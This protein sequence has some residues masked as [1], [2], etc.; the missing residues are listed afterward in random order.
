MGDDTEA[1]NNESSDQPKEV[2]ENKENQDKESLSSA[3]EVTGLTDAD[4]DEDLSEDRRKS[5]SNETSIEIKSELKSGSQADEIYTAQNLE[6]TKIE[7]MYVHQ[8]GSSAK[9]RLAKEH[10]HIVSAAELR[11]ETDSL[12]LDDTFVCQ[13]LAMLD[14]HR[15]LLITGMPELGKSSL[16]LRLA[17]DLADRGIDDSSDISGREPHEVR[18]KH[19]L[20]QRL[21]FSLL[22]ICNDR[23]LVENRILLFI[24]PFA[25]GNTSLIN[26]PS[27]DDDGYLR[28]LG[29]R[30]KEARAYI[31]LTADQETL[32]PAW[33]DTIIEQD[34]P[35]PSDEHL[36][37]LLTDQLSKHDLSLD[38]AD[39]SLL[40]ERLN[41]LPKISGFAKLFFP[42]L[43]DDSLKLQDALIRHSHVDAWFLR[44]VP[45]RNQAAWRLC[46]AVML[47][48]AA[49]GVDAVLSLAA[50]ELAERLRCHFDIQCSPRDS[51]QSGPYLLHDRDLLAFAHLEYQVGT[52][53]TGPV[54]RFVE[55]FMA[56][57]LWDAL[58]GSGHSLLV[59]LR[60]FLDDL[61]KDSNSTSSFI[62]TACLGRIG[63]LAPHDITRPFI[64]RELK[65]P[66]W[67]AY[68]PLAG[69]FLGIRAS[70]NKHYCDSCLDFLHQRCRNSDRIFTF[71]L[72][73]R[74]IG[75]H[76][77][78]VAVKSLL[79]TVQ[80]ILGDKLEAIR[81]CWSDVN[82]GVNRGTK[83]AHQIGHE[84]STIGEKRWLKERLLRFLVESQVFNKFQKETF[85]AASFTLVGL[86][87]GQDPVRLASHCLSNLRKRNDDLLPLVALFWLD[88]DG[89]FAKMAK[90]PLRLDVDGNGRFQKIDRTVAGLLENKDQLEGFANFLALLDD[91]LKAYPPSI[92]N[93]L[94]NQML[95]FLKSW[96]SGATKTE[97]GETVML[98]LLQLLGQACNHTL[99]DDVLDML[100][101]DPVFRAKGTPLWNLATEILTSSG[102]SHKRISKHL[103][104]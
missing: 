71:M 35:P 68:K 100:Q 77:P 74:E 93:Q 1:E 45:E 48:Y 41:T 24:D 95:A 53:D 52:N 51:S 15:L 104:Q 62:A 4:A 14:Q 13:C 30:L 90:Y 59:T 43:K 66:P 50:H 64:E 2:E 12:L 17:R 26:E 60:P 88:G 21:Q 18:V 87:F 38:E 76:E 55:P 73:L 9:Q 56:K 85:R 101:K 29:V 49:R 96:A 54:L 86:S 19:Q 46:L 5:Q 40:R 84:K 58:L 22:D 33:R 37:T 10:F 97:R 83:V 20:E 61:A 16:A 98:R 11:C 67:H 94:R 103:D 23:R 102:V 6:L 42:S 63:E 72:V 99:W 79:E 81:S 70:H 8:S 27:L 7:T 47:G 69:L 28:S 89:V 34:T 3:D 39:L 80:D 75:L 31:I 36:E 57:Q 91:S 32:S 25:L 44:E 78:A 92:V 65:N 82:E